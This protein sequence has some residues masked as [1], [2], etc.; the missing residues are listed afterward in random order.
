MLEGGCLEG[1]GT[2]EWQNKGAGLVGQAGRGRGSRKCE[3]PEKEK[4]LE[5]SRTLSGHCN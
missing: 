5:C 4:T 3:G 1:V 2:G